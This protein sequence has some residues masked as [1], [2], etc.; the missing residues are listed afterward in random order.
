MAMRDIES[1]LKASTALATQAISSDTTTNGSAID[2]SG[3]E[4]I[5]ASYHTGALTDGTY[6]PIVLEGDDTN[7][8]N[9]SAVADADLLPSGTGQETSAAISVANTT[10]QVGYRG[11]KRYVFFGV[12]SS[13]TTTGATVGATAIQGCPNKAP[14]S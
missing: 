2:M 6:T 8:Q 1:K 12:V 13:D 3:Y 9:A 10:T 5:V 4:A 7:V 11:T 14:I